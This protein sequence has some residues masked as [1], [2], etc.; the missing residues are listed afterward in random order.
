MEVELIA[1]G[2][3]WRV[4]VSREGMEPAELGT[5]ADLHDGR[6]R[7]TTNEMKTPA[8]NIAGAEITMQAA[9]LDDVREQLRTRTKL[10]SEKP[11]HLTADTMAEYVA[12]QLHNL[13]ALAGRCGAL[14]GFL[15][16]ITAG[17]GGFMA[18]AL[19]EGATDDFL[20]TL[21]EHLKT[22]MEVAREAEGCADELK[23]AIANALR[24][25]AP[26]ND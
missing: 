1:A 21:C 12:S 10:L 15:D 4:V 5:L 20:E 26:L 25:G 3:C 18:R 8:G 2:E 7:V 23:D 24:G 9:S 13:E 19:R 17:L 11:D 22:E 16:G 14:R 6:W